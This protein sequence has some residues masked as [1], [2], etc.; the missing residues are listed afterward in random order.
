[1]EYNELVERFEM[2]EEFQF[3]Y[4]NDSYW[5]S[6]NEEEYFLTRQRDSFSQSFESARELFNNGKIEDKTILEL[7]DSI[8]I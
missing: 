4:K 2:G 3:Y 1:M 7:W 5:I 6:Q 8:E